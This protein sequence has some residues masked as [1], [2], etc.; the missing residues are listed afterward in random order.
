[1]NWIRIT[2]GAVDRPRWINMATVVCI[3]AQGDPEDP[4]TRGLIHTVDGKSVLVKESFMAL[5]K[6]ILSMGRLIHHEPATTTNG[7]EASG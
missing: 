4:N 3:D 2:I 1:M 5:Q 6:H 7:D